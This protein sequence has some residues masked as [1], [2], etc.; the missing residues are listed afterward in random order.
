MKMKCVYYKQIPKLDKKKGKKRKKRNTSYST[1]YCTAAQHF[2]FV[3]H[4]GLF[5]VL[6]Q[7]IKNDCGTCSC[8][9]E[10][11]KQTKKKLVFVYVVV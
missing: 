5:G 1:E 8:K 4:V 7:R 2:L 10:K 3:Q 9:K 6:G 11:T